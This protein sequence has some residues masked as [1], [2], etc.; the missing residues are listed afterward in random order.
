MVC[1]CTSNLFEYGTKIFICSCLDWNIDEDLLGKFLLEQALFVMLECLKH[2][3]VSKHWFHKVMEYVLV[4]IQ[5]EGILASRF[6]Q[7]PREISNTN[8][9][10]NGR[11]L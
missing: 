10:V 1:T 5:N 9:S 4:S 8:M 6:D 11:E 3:F 2:T 7:I